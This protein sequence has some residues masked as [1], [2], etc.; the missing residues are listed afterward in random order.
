MSYFEPQAF[1]FDWFR[2]RVRGSFTGSIR[3]CQGTT[4]FRGLGVQG[5]GVCGLGFTSGLWV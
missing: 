2:G 4:G 5:L 1:N 3:A